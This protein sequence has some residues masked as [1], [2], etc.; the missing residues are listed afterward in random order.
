MKEMPWFGRAFDKI[1]MKFDANL[2]V[3]NEFFDD[4]VK[5]KFCT[6]FGLGPS[7]ISKPV[8]S[9]SSMVDF[10]YFCLGISFVLLFEI[11]I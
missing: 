7:G 8:F 10:F 4:S 3:E 9:I 5:N 2:K 6:G 11:L 1:W